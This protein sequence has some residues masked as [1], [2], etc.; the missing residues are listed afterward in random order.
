[1]GDVE[2]DDESEFLEANPGEATINVVCPTV[3][4]DSSL[5]GQTLEI[6][7]SSLADKIV[8]LKRS[9]KPLAGDLAQNKQKLST[10]GLGFL[11]D[12]ASL[13]YYNLKDGSTLNLSIKSRGKR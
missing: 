1:M 4:G 11:K 10:L 9:I 13:A 3:E 8:D 7:V 2:L 5:T 12:T 6:K